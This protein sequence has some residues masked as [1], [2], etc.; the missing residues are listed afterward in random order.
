MNWFLNFIV[1]TEM[2]KKIHIL[3]IFILGYS[4]YA[5]CQPAIGSNRNTEIVLD[6]LYPPSDLIIAYQTDW[7]KAHYP[8]RIIEFREHPLNYN[9]IIFLGN[10]ITEQGGDWGQYFNSN[11]I[12]NRGISGDVTEGVLA[13]LGEINH[14]KPAAVFLLIGIND[15]YL[16]KTPQFVANNVLKIVKTI[17]QASPDTKIF[18]Q[19]VFPTTNPKMVDK[20]LETNNLLQKNVDPELF[21]LIDLYSLLS[22]KDDFLINKYTSDGL[23]LSKKGY[24]LWTKHLE[25]II[26]GLLA[27]SSKNTSHK[28]Y[29]SPVGND[30]N[31]GSLYSPWISI[32]YGASQ[33][34]PG[35]TLIVAKGRYK[36]QEIISKSG[37]NGKYITILGEEGAYIEGPATNR[38]L[39]MLT[40]K[41]A[42]YVIIDGLTVKNAKTHGIMVFGFCKHIEIKNCRTEH[43]DGCGI[44]VQGTAAHSWDQKYYVSNIIIDNNEIHW[45]QE[46]S[47]NG[48]LLWHED[49][50][51]MYGVEKFEIKNNYINAYDTVNYNGGPIAIDVKDGVRY[52]SIHHNK[53]E[54][55]PSTGIYVD[56][57]DSHVH[58][59]DIFQNYILNVTAYGIQIGAERGGTIDSVKVY[60]NVISKVGW[61]GIISGD[62]TGGD[63]P[64]PQPKTHIDIFNNTI[65]ETGLKGW[66]FGIRTQSSFKQG[67][68]FNNIIFNT[69]AD[70]LSVNANDNNVVNNNCIYRIGGDKGELGE[71]YI[72]KNPQFVNSEQGDFS[73]KKTS[74]CIDVGIKYHL[75][76]I[77]FN[78]ANLPVG[79]G[80]DIGAYEYGGKGVN[81]MSYFPYYNYSG[82]EINSDVDLYTKE[83]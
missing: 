81:V 62:Y 79:K 67:K 27:S 70:G 18:V 25:P 52:G 32:S 47:F 24:R 12:A 9:E 74:P 37:E 50:T 20:I 4:T 7:T 44:L 48:N 39:G 36:Q 19:T 30:R 82:K 23:H 53:I 58:N 15:L 46:G 63:E 49:I 3:L 40:L 1:S 6:S 34:M 42:N 17:K 8:K 5:W 54:N 29:V 14:F 65:Y 41:D 2:I 55:I 51:L 45:P 33:L 69:N 75:R 26:D 11:R 72:L 61:C 10:S 59:I 73:L 13:R 80:I 43:T 57:W 16:A 21:K 76:K 60:N 71:N 68:I 83:L 77:D 31:T 64:L 22:N 28:Y 78:G 66:G 38:G 35:D 56:A